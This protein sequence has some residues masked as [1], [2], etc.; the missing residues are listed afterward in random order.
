MTTSE[1]S[2]HDI[3]SCNCSDNNVRCKQ[4]RPH[5]K[6]LF[7]SLWRHGVRKPTAYDDAHISYKIHRPGRQRQKP[8]AQEQSALALWINVESL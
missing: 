4:S 7:T 5:L 1:K 2:K 3:Q 8:A 6:I